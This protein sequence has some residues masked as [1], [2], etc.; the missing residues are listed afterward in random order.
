MSGNTEMDQMRNG[1]QLGKGEGFSLF[2]GWPSLYKQEILK[3][4]ALV[5]F[6]K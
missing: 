5:P 1:R 2:S 4:F 6:N 3:E